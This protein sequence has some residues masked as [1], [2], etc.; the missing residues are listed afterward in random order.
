MRYPCTELQRSISF[1]YCALDMQVLCI[2]NLDWLPLWISM[3]FWLKTALICVQCNAVR[4]TWWL[5][6]ALFIL[7]NIL[8]WLCFLWIN[9]F[10]YPS[11]LYPFVE[12]SVAYTFG[13]VLSQFYCHRAHEEFGRYLW[14]PAINLM[15]PRMLALCTAGTLR[16]CVCVCTW[17][18]GAYNYSALVSQA[19]R[20]IL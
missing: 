6:R 16:V 17:F 9:S 13:R 14:S 5:F 12:Y 20:L 7:D 2:T 11:I 10:S 4:Y 18:Y 1:A 19:S 8:V 15:L 3:K